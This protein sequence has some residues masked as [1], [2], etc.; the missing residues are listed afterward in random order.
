MILV[1]YRLYQS[2]DNL[3]RIYKYPLEKSTII[4]KKSNEY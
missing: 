3:N 2:I 1:G 4:M